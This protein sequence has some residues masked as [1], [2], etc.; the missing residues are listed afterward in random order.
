MIGTTGYS[1][2]GSI[3]TDGGGFGWLYSQQIVSNVEQ[4][5]SDNCIVEGTVMTNQQ[6][7][8]RHFNNTAI[9]EILHVMYALNTPDGHI[10]DDLYIMYP[11]T[12][13]TQ[14]GNKPGVY[15]IA[16]EFSPSGLADPRFR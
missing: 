12:V 10:A 14:Q 1:L 11:A 4:G 3:Q 13:F 9:H 7:I 2:P 5:C 16:D 6:I 8:C 15:T